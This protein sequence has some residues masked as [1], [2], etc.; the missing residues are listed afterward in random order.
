MKTGTKGTV[1]DVQVFTRD[2][3]SKDE[4]A[5]AIEDQQMHQIRKDLDEELR[6]V[7][8]ATYSRL[9]SAFD[10]RPSQMVVQGLKKGTT[11]DVE[12]LQGLD[13]QDWFTLA[14]C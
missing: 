1:I 4:R 5:L 6:I 12:L 11:L 10:G 7:Q 2:G 3:I 9:L 8:E 14:V 13:R